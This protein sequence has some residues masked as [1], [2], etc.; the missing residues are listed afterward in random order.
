MT[1][2][3]ALSAREYEILLDAAETYREVLVVRCC[4]EVG[5]RPAELAVLT[6]GN[7]EQVRIDPPRYVVRVPPTGDHTAHTD[8]TQHRTAYL[9]TDVEQEIR[10]YARSND[11]SADDHL[12]DVTPRRLQML[13]AEVATRAADRFDRPALADVSSS[14]LRQYF[15]RRSLVD[16]DINPRAVKA[17][18][19]WQS[20]EAL[21]SYLPEPSDT[22]LVDAFE[23]VER[24]STPR[25]AGASGS[26]R[27]GRPMS[28]DSVVRLLL[29]ASD[30]Y[31]LVRLDEEGYVE[32]WNR[33]A[34]AL[35]G[36]RAGEIVGTHVSAFYTEKAV[37]DGVPEQTLSTALEEAGTEQEG[38]RV[39]SDGS[40]FRA[41]EVI[42]PLRDDRGRHDGYAVFV[43]DSSAQH[44]VLESVRAERDELRRA[45]A[46]GER[47]RAVTAA[48]LEASDHEAAEAMVCDSLVAG[49]AYAF[50]WIDRTT[51]TDREGR[52]TT[53]GERDGSEVDAATIERLVP[54]EWR[55]GEQEGMDDSS[56]YESGSESETESGVAITTVT[57]KQHGNELALAS[58][59]LIYGDTTYGRLGVA[60]TRPDAF[61][62]DEKRWLAT[63]GRQI[64]YAIT[65][66]R[67]R[68]LLLSD[69]V[70]ELDVRC[71]DAS[72]FF[73]AASQQ[74]GCRFELDSL[75]PIS[76]STQLYYLRLEDAPPAE[77]FD[78]AADDPGIDD[79]RLLET[80]PD[81]WRIEVVVEGSS[82]ARTLT[83]YGL[84][85]LEAVTEAGVTTITAE[86][87]AE[88]NL[89]TVLEGL[90]STFPSSTLLGKRETER[91][92]QT[93]REFRDGLE[94]RLTE[95]QVTA[96]R[97]AYFGGYYDW[98]R[99]STAE[100]VADAMGISS[101]TLHN[102]LRKGQHEL[103]RTFFDVP[104]EGQSRE[105]VS[106]E[107]TSGD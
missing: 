105:S 56:T 90:R 7:V 57:D 47:Y 60:T 86:A 33:S 79:C 34:A 61:A 32:R 50:S 1:A 98:P 65:A 9:P 81:G 91:T 102:H 80:D 44:E 78:L 38:W 51:G 55:A 26:G 94:E 22:A 59:P 40:R 29:A 15:A 68:N 11:L 106:D 20:F 37:D 97:A 19:G 89:R 73:V 100:E 75:V 82:P 104:S 101:P 95:R 83:E 84:T 72:S 49:E 2:E 13:V 58:V 16:H 6:V 45:V 107:R 8:S 18:G 31:A 4:G 21:E 63:A 62:A 53:S 74:L 99:E 30:R 24:P 43:R 5:L 25:V 70:V 64:G 85:V 23:T 54:A 42:S 28:D 41:T 27:T 12:L 52:R 93:A 92:V 48:L 14:D 3:A 67:R 88:L 39:H 17:A 87:A 96:L 77:V 103:L 36:Y 10:R 46:V 35:L 71:Q 66:V 76:E 69:R